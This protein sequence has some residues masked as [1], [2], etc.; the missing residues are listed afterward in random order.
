LI[1]GRQFDQRRLAAGDDDFLAGA[2]WFDQAR[3]VGLGVVV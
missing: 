1:Q 2:R 3:Q